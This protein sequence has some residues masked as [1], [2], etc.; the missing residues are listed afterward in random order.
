MTKVTRPMVDVRVRPEELMAPPV[1]D[2]AFVYERIMHGDE[3]VLHAD[4]DREFPQRQDPFSIGTWRSACLKSGSE[5]VPYTVFSTPTSSK[6]FERSSSGSFDE[7]ATVQGAER[8]R[9]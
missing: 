6:N 9:S 1:H 2:I 7:L 5:S 8:M 3:E 4:E